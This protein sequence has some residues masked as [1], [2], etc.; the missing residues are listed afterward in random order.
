MLG[1]AE[2]QVRVRLA[3]DV[4][5][6]AGRRT[7]PRRGWPTCSTSR[8]CRPPRSPCREHGVG[9]GRAAEVVQRVRVAQD[10]L[11]RARDQRCGRRAARRAAR[12]AAS[13]ACRPDDS[14]VFVVSLPAVTSCTKKTAE[15]EV[16]HVGCRRTRSRACSV[17]RSSARL[18][19]APASGDAASRTSPCPSCRSRD[20]S[21]R[22][23]GRSPGPGRCVFISAMWWTRSPVLLGQAHQLADHPRRQARR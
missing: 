22:R 4:E 9:R 6:S 11:D 17:V 23:R 8:P 2:R 3:V 16:G 20:S 19:R 10:L 12:G 5:A 14:I 1:D 18:L 21:R 13:R 7:R 15:V